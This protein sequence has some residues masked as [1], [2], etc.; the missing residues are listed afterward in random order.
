ME[1]FSFFVISLGVLKMLRDKGMEKG[2]GKKRKKKEK[3]VRKMRG[4][5]EKKENK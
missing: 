5:E 2:E 1:V 3:K 4:G